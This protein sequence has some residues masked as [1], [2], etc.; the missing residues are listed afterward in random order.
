M[1]VSLQVVSASRLLHTA[2]LHGEGL[3]Y[4]RDCAQDAREDDRGNQKQYDRVCDLD[5]HNVRLCGPQLY[6]HYYKNKHKSTMVLNV[7]LC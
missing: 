7:Q 3:E 5:H 1:Q 6:E 2:L 4:V